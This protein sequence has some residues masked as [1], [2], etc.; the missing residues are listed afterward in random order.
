MFYGPMTINYGENYFITQAP[1]LI[2]PKHKT[3]IIRIAVYLRSD[4]SSGV[5]IVTYSTPLLRAL[6]EVTSLHPYS[7]WSQQK[8]DPS[9]DLNPAPVYQVFFIKH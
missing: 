1:E 3:P 5:L 7:I 6:Y 9:Q 4:M 2:L 8:I